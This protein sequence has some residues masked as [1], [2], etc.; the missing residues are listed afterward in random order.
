M[1]SV[2]V[3]L[4]SVANKKEKLSNLYNF[5]MVYFLSKIRRVFYF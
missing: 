2:K 5:I 4:V 1:F 3:Q